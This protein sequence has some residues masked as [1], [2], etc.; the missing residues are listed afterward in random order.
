MGARLARSGWI[1]SRVTGG[2]GDADDLAEKPRCISAA[3]D[4]ER[5]YRLSRVL[6][7]A[8]PSKR[9]LPFIATSVSK[10]RRASRPR[11]AHSYQRSALRFGARKAQG[12][13]S[14]L[15]A[16]NGIGRDKWRRS[17]Q[18]KAAVGSGPEVRR[19]PVCENP[20]VVPPGSGAPNCVDA[21][22]SV[23]RVASQVVRPA[24]RRLRRIMSSSST[25]P[26]SPSTSRSVD[27]PEPV[28][29]HAAIQGAARTGPPPRPP[30][31]QT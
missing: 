5:G 20:A 8:F 12:C 17:L 3:N 4:L 26:R 25:S 10:S 7:S 28:P 24:S 9:L 19:Y 11:V 16:W 18:A 15:R 31:T 1:T 27:R 21:F 2:C 23:L 6:A 30:S 13:K 14:G 29:P 22:H